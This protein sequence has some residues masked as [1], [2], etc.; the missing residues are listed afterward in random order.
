ML[1]KL[2]QERIITEF[3]NFFPTRAATSFSMLQH[4]RH[5]GYWHDLIFPYPGA[6]PSGFA[7]L[8]SGGLPL[9]ISR[10]GSV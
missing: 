9:I 1:H 2:L 8:D 3:V 7:V 6:H 5:K 10:D 4:N